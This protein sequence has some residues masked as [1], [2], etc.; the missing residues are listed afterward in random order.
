MKELDY[1]ERHYL[2]AALG[3]LELGNP[4][5]AKAETDQISWLNRFHPEVFIVRWRIHSNLGRWE[6]ARDLAH[7]FSR[8]C[9]DRPSGWLCLSY[10]LYKLKRP[11]EAYLQL[12]H[13]A[14]TFP[15]VSAIPYFLACYSWELGDHKGAGKW[16]A[17]WKAL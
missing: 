6:T 17:K 15:Q 12:V 8:V 1:P 4:A 5:E 7:I 11:V 10:S 16:L 14:E 2:N 9:P 13:R 3:W